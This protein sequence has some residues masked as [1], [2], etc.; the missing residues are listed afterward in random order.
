MRRHTGEQRYQC[1]IC[2]V[3][4]AANGGLKNHVK[5]IHEHEPKKPCPFPCEKDFTTIGNMKV[6]PSRHTHIC[7]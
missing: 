5:R 4:F 3:K 6:S 1:Q 7:R 2:F